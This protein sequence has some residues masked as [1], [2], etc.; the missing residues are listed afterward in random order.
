[1]TITRQVPVETKRHATNVR[2]YI[3]SPKAIMRDFQNISNKNRWAYEMDAIREVSGHNRAARESSKNIL[4]FHEFLAFLPDECDMNGG[5]MTAEMCMQYAKEYAKT[6]YPN[7]QVAFALHNEYCREDKTR[8]YAVHMAINRTDLETRKRFH[9]GNVQQSLDKRVQFVRGLDQKWGLQQVQEGVQNSKIHPRQPSRIGA[10]RAIIDRAAG[11]GIEPQKASYKYNLRELCK[12]LQTEAKD[13]DEYRALLDKYG[14]ATEIKGRRLFVTDKD[15][16]RYSFL[17]S[18]LDRSL[19]ANALQ[20]VFRRNSGDRDILRIEQEFAA[21]GKTLTDYTELRTKYVNAVKTRL[22]DYEKSVKETKTKPDDFPK[23]KI[24]RIPAELKSD[25]SL[26]RE[27][28]NYTR[29]ADRLRG[30]LLNDPA[31]MKKNKSSGRTAA[32]DRTPDS[33][34]PETTKTRSDVR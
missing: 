14:V 26:S 2:N 18:R 34:T 31:A 27:I 21:I 19:T 15:N 6:R 33:R 4:M 25:M 12:V 28:L 32:A 13:L 30:E 20:V 22:A 16:A 17:L 10:E 8:R 7:H 1:M 11:R 9:E 24:P 3:N 23:F 5:K 29:R